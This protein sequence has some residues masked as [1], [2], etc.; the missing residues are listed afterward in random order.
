MLE[1]ADRISFILILF[2]STLNSINVPP[3]KSIP[4]FKPLKIIRLNLLEQRK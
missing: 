1:K 2:D 3:L 4:K